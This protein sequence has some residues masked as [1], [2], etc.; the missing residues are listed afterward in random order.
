MVMVSGPSTTRT[1]LGWMQESSPR[2]DSVVISVFAIV[3]LS[4]MGALFNSNHHALMGST[5][6]PGD[7]PAVAATV[8]AAVLVYVVSSPSL[9]RRDL[10]LPFH[11][12][13]G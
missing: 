9:Q 12:N 13:L 2:R 4:V 6:D 7:G 8:F 1:P 3:I 11:G 5:H 10:L